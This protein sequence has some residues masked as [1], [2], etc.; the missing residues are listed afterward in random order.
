M[1]AAYSHSFCVAAIYPVQS[2]VHWVSKCYRFLSFLFYFFQMLQTYIYMVIKHIY[3]TAQTLQH[4]CVENTALQIVSPDAAW[5]IHVCIVQYVRIVSLYILY[6]GIKENE[7]RNNS[8]VFMSIDPKPL[9]SIARVR[10]GTGAHF[11]LIHYFSF[12]TVNYK[13]SYYYLHD[14]AWSFP[15]H[16]HCPFSQQTST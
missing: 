4:H 15:E 10:G 9:R 3:L 6:M 16:T 14:I 8:C 11:I 7:R 2:N 13:N 12:C 1:S 5:D